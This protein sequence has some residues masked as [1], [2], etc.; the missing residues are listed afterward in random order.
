MRNL[1]SILIRNV[2][3]EDY[4][5]NRRSYYQKDWY[6]IPY[7]FYLCHSTI[8]VYFCQMRN[9]LSWGGFSLLFEMHLKTYLKRK[10]LIRMIL[11]D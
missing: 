10:C 8:I 9:L 6:D 5:D 7:E 1:F 11:F 2:I 4:E 3:Q